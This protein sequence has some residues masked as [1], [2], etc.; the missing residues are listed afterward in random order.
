MKIAEH[1]PVRREFTLTVSEDELRVITESLNNSGT[2]E[3]GAATDFSVWDT[4]NDFMD[5]NNI[6]KLANL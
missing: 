6:K 3:S 1:K 2:L 5:D 4:L